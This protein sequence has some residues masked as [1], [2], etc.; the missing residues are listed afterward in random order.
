MGCRCCFGEVC[1][2][3]KVEREGVQAEIC[4][5]GGG[6]LAGKGLGLGKVSIAWVC[7]GG[8]R[9][10]LLNL[11]WSVSWASVGFLS[12]TGIASIIPR[13]RFVSMSVEQGEKSKV[14]VRGC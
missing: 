12:A 9:V 10:R 4:G 11:G 14:G 2:K 5:C 7:G 3:G 1:W 8:R 13:M 6:V